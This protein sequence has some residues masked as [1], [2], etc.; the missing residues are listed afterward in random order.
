VKFQLGIPHLDLVAAVQPCG[1]A[2]HRFTIQGGHVLSAQVEQEI[3]LA[4]A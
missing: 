2:V 3:A 1:G 4:A